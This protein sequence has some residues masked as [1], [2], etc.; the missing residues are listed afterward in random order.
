[1]N[2]RIPAR[3]TARITAHWQ[4]R[5]PRD[6][7]AIGAGMLLLAV[8]M[9]YAYA[10]LPLAR[11]RIDLSQSAP[12]LRAE[13]LQMRNSAAEVARLQSAARPTVVELRTAIE[14]AAQTHGIR[15]AISKI[16]SEGAGRVQVRLPAVRA[17]EWF[18]WA[19]RLQSELGIRVETVRMEAL[20][21][22]DMTAVVA[23]LSRGE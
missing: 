3:I 20:A 1:M 7:L 8:S 13:L 6:R 12:R 4:Q 14:Q 17:S 11:D 15:K 10:W 18:A 5:L 9:V 22:A 21:D 19:A 23:T 16:D 2:S